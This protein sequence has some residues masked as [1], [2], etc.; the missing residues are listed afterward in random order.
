MI[1]MVRP[2]ATTV[3]ATE[4]RFLTTDDVRRSVGLSNSSTTRETIDRV[5]TNTATGPIATA[6][7]DSFYGINHRKQP[8]AIAINKDESGL[9]FFT[10]PR[11]N[12]TAENLRNVRQLTPLLNRETASLQRIVRS[13]LDPES[14]WTTAGACPFVDPQQAF[15]PI[16][17]N[18]LLSMSGWPDLEAKFTDSQEGVYKEA[19]ALVDAHPLFHSTYDITANFRNLP[20]DPITLIFLTWI[21]YMGFVAEGSLSPYPDSILL[22]EVDYDTRIYRLVMD[23]TKTYIQKIAACGACFPRGVPIGAAFNFDSTQPF[24]DTSN[25]IS[26]PFHAMGAMYMDDI[27]AAEFNRTV[28]IFNDGMSDAF[29]AKKYTKIPYAALNIFNHRGYPRINLDTYE[30]EWWIDTATYTAKM[31]ILKDVKTL[32]ASQAAGQDKSS[33]PTSY[34]S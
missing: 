21:L 8:S 16:L 29:R 27:L 19:Y 2:N 5:L 24:G 12:L 15:M 28:Q 31:P 25:Q 23:P 34:W 17:S 3:T 14:N 9:T 22:N 4:S 18:H 7:G 30:L 26:I 1:T 32:Q 10:R 13:L 11:L 33:P 6:I 20:G